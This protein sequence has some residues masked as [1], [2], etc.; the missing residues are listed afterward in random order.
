MKDFS[1]VIPV[2]N[3]SE[4]L[5]IIVSEIDTLKKNYNKTFEVIFINDGSTDDSLPVLKNLKQKRDDIKILS[6]TRNFGQTA[7]ISAGFDHAQSDIVVTLDADLQ[8]D[9]QDIPALIAE[10][11]KG[12]DLVSGWRKQ[13]KDNFFVRTFP[14]L[15]ANCLISCCTKVRL[16]DYG[17]TLKAYKRKLVLDIDLYAELH[18]FLPALISW[19][20]CK[21][22]EIPVNHRKR[23]FG[24]SKYGLSKTLNVILD[25]ITVKFMLISHRGPMQIF[26]RWGLLF[27]FLG[28]VSGVLTLAMKVFN[29]FD[30]TGNP[31]L[32]LTI[33]WMMMSLLFVSIGLLG[34]L[35]LRSYSQSSKRKIYVIETVI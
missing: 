22:S 28:F 16:H 27:S 8:N 32:Y 18:R 31:L 29:N 25:L 6:F 23:K 30:M 33:F 24:K 10:M 13:R 14:S 2:Y 7:A 12:F 19:L 21:I 1:L 34:E 20:G 15:L 5:P 9:P 3:E 17:C 26:G 35:N 11:E 4:N